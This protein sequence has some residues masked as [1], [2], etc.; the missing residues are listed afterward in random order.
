MNKCLVTKLQTVVSNPNLPVLDTITEFALSKIA[1][2]G[3]KVMTDDQKWHVSRFFNRLQGPSNGPIWQKID[4]MFLPIISGTLK[5]ALTDIKGETKEGSSTGS[6][7][8]GE[9]GYLHTS[10][11]AIV[12]RSDYG[13]D[14]MDFGYLVSVDTELGSYKFLQIDGVNVEL[15]ILPGAYYNKSLAI[16]NT[17]TKESDQTETLFNSIYSD[18]TLT[19]SVYMRDSDNNNLLLTTEPHIVTSR[20]ESMVG[21]HGATKLNSISEDAAGIGAIIVGKSFTQ[22]ESEIILEAITTLKKAFPIES[23]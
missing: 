16:Y 3:N 15:S 19:Q 5:G 9:D 4:F 21:I 6:F 14:P 7:T 23:V 22:Q 20:A 12:V 11:S 2:A 17:L 18:D 8:L 1:V 10:G 13:I